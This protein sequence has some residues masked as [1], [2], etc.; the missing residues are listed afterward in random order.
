MRKLLYLFVCLALF[1]ACKKDRTSDIVPVDVNVKVGYQTEASGY[2]LPL[3]NI[4]VK[5]KNVNT[6]T[7]QLLTTNAEGKVLF[8]AVAAGT[9]DIDATIKISSEDYKNITG[10][11]TNTDII[12]NA[13]LKNKVIS[14]GFKDVLELKLLTGNIGDWVI[15]QVYY[16]GSH[17]TNGAT[18]RD[19]FIECYNNS[20]KTLY[21]DSLYF[22]EITGVITS[23]SS[24]NVLGNG[25]MDWSKAVG[26]PS[27]VN[28][29]NDY[30][31]AR[32]VLMIPGTGKQYPVLPGK[33]IVVAQTAINHKSPFTGTD[34]KTVSVVDPSLTVDLS[35]ADF[36]AY[37]A[38][39]LAKPL[40]S[41]VDTPAPN[42]EVISYFGTDMIFDN[43][44]RYSYI[45]FKADA[46]TKVKD[47]PQYPYPT[48]STPSSTATKY[49]QIPI[50][51][52]LDA[53]EVQS[54]LP[55]DRN[56]KKLNASLDAGFTFVPA[57]SYT[58]QSII[59]KTEK[60]VDGRIVLKD[61]NNST[62]DF[63]FFNIATPRGFK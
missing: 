35:S 1:S 10:I 56:P 37:Y 11:A 57:G 59:R 20:G 21:A 19:Q 48:K 45:L 47:L 9:Y 18:Y 36:E 25:Q 53:V 50:N 44:G 8:S 43:P 32:A 62:E 38:P 13:S 39:F 41:D 7:S 58:S 55:D 2:T 16:A 34:G 40:S 27:D 24:Y 5:I 52:I 42:L 31:Y 15:K 51:L 6:G 28:A 14:V 61:T 12:Y 29:N 33:S 17:R 60:T 4:S 26:M 54:N 46:K 23:G 49:Y 3:N 22:A 63:D 30:V